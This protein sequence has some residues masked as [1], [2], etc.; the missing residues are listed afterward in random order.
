MDNVL[1]PAEAFSPG[2]YLRDELEERGWTATEF[3]EIIERPLQVVSEIMNDKK[4]ITAETAVEISEAL[5]TSAELWLTLQ[6]MYRLDAVRRSRPDATSVTRRAQ[7]RSLVP[8][9]EMQKRGWL[10][11]TDDVA[12]I[13]DAVFDL[14]GISDVSEVPLFAIAARRSNADESY[15]PEQMAWVA[16]VRKLGRGRATAAFDRLRLREVA[17]DLA[18]RIH[19][20][21]DLAELRAWMAAC[22]VALVIERPLRSSKIDGVVV[23]SEREGPIVGLSTRW[24]RMDSF[25]FTLLHEIAHLVLE[26]VV[27]GQVQLDR[28]IFSDDD[29]AREMAA[30]DLA[31]S[32]ILPDISSDIADNPKMTD[33]LA[34]AREHR[35]HASFVIGRLQRDG[36]IGWGEFRRTIPKVRPYVEFG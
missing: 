21:L 23:F 9:R 22:G 1:K 28:D 31:G 6:A 2:E 27:P 4:E 33:I 35:V 36:K 16:R 12:E 29:S 19:D 18:H 5:G 20:P 25:I 26:H 10:P 34:I 17:A 30:N 11:E 13:E 24:D 3:A 14:L 15:S 7:I 32:W 8:V